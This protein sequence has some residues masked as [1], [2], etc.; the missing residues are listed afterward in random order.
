M[1]LYRQREWKAYCAEQ[2][3]LHNGVCAYCLRSANEVVLQVHH[4]K[5]VK[6]CLPWEYPYDEC[7]VL[8]R[9]CHAKE[10]GIIKPSND[11]ELIGQDD[12]GG[13]DGECEHCGK[14]LRYTHM[15]THPNWGT[16]IVGAQCC[17]KLTETT[18]GSQGHVDFLNYVSRRKTFI[19]SPKWAVEPN[20][21]RSIE[22]AGIAIQIVPTIE[23]KFRFNLDEVKGQAD[24]STLLDA[25]IKVFDYVESGD[26]ATYLAERRQKIAERN[27]K[28][29]AS[30]PRTG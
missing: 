3:K 28:F 11:W 17:D 23:G 1:K 10:H 30:S 27:A 22:R 2:I 18:I 9:G 26:A 16:M 4:T 15:V 6:G 25:Q 14:E 5:Y 8:C 21:V 29:M 24:Y 19:N 13:L 7:E 20:G 12:L